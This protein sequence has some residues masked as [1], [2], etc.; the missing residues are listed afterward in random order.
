LLLHAPRPFEGHTK[1]ITA[2]SDRCPS[3]RSAR[4]AVEP[5]EGDVAKGVTVRALSSLTPVTAGR[6][7]EQRVPVVCWKRT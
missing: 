3:G 4:V 5:G 6:K 2:P 1:K 7:G